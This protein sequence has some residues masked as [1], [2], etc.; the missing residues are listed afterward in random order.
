MLSPTDFFSLA[1]YSH[2][3]STAYTVMDFLENGK[4]IALGKVATDSDLLDINFP[5]KI[6]Q[7]IDIDGNLTIN[8]KSIFDLIY[9]I[10]SIYMSVNETDPS[11][12]FGG[13]W[14]AWGKGILLRN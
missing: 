1:E 4:G 14:T 6:R 9:P 3:L 8:N 11:L 7:N 5:T 12:L 10:G 13:T 2:N